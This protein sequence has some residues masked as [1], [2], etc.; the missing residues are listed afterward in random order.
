[1]SF[2]ERLDREASVSI[3]FMWWIVFMPIDNAIINL[4]GY[5]AACTISTLEAR[6]KYSV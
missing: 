2:K 5:A 6:F 4:L 3:A 1:V